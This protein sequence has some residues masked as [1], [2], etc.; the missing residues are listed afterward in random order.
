[1]AE[2][3]RHIGVALLPIMPATAEKIL[4]QFGITVDWKNFDWQSAIKWG[5]LGSGNKITKCSALFP[6]L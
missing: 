3:L 6:R 5:G 1:M 4:A 2:A